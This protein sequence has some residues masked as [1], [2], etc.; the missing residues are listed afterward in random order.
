MGFVKS[1]VG[2]CVD[3]DF[4]DVQVKILVQWYEKWKMGF[5]LS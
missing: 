3:K 2:R 1:L 4:F 5:F